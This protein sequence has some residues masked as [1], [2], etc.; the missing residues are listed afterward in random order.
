MNT[1]RY[2]A[3]TTLV[4]AGVAPASAVE[5]GS[6]PAVSGGVVETRFVANPELGRAWIEVTVHD[7]HQR[8]DSSLTQI[9]HHSRF[10]VPGLSFDAATSQIVFAQGG[11]L[12]S[13]ADVAPRRTLFGKT[14]AVR[15]T[16]N[17]AIATESATLAEDDGFHVRK[18]DHVQL[19]LRIGDTKG[20]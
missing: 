14:T 12:I 20:G 5:I 19:R 17:C 2:I 1:L 9:V 7:P 13:C 8:D 6:V 3:A 4:L 16:G 15:P 18:R 10:K 11:N